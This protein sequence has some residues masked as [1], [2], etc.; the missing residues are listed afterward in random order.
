[1]RTLFFRA[2]ESVRDVPRI[3]WRADVLVRRGALKMAVGTTALQ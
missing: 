1:M 2:R 3:F